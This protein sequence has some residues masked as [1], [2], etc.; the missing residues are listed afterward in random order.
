M[1][2]TGWLTGVFTLYFVAAFLVP[3]V[4][5]WRSTGR[6][7]YVLPSADDAYGFVS[8]AM[9]CVIA[10]LFAYFTVRLLWPAVGMQ[11][12][13]LH[14]PAAATLAR[15][16][17]AALAVAICW[18]VTAQYQM[19]LSWRIGI[20]RKTGTALVTSGLFG[21][22][23]NPIFLAMRVC[24]GALVLVQPNAVTLAFFLAGDLVMQFQVRLEE[25]FL[26]QQHGPAYE[27]YCARVRRWL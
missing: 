15:A 10:G 3:T 20:D 24:L 13:A 25:D 22:S 27:Q 7:P 9:K 26:R 4:R 1:N 23:R 5:V 21:W 19:G 12:G 6:N 8:R 2:E 11:M 18:T 14:L 17:W 16:G